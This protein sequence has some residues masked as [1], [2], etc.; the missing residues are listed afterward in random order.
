MRVKVNN[1]SLEVT[2]NNILT[3]AVEAIVVVTD[4]NLSLSETLLAL[5]GEQVREQT[6]QI[7]WADV[8]EAV[9]TDAGNLTNIR[10]IIHAVGPRWGEGSERGK[11]GN[12]TWECLL[13]AEKHGLKSVALPAISVGTLGY[14]LEACSKIMIS[15]V[16]DFTFER[17][18]NLQNIILCLSNPSEFQTFRDE[19]NRQIQDLRE[20]GEG[21]IRA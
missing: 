13:V 15:R 20:T 21:K 2:Q 8:G 17:L 16:I 12:V 3:L 1:I 18:H 11:L 10:K 19:F 7:A 6:S 5:V 14:P 4:P 9:I